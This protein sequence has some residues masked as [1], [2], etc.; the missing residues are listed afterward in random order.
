MNA[1]EYIELRQS[2]G[3]QVRRLSGNSWQVTCP[4]HEDR[5]PSLSVTAEVDRVLVKCHT[6]CP[7]EAVVAADGLDLAD[8]FYEPRKGRV[9]VEVYRYV[10]E[11]GTPLFEVVRFEPKEFRQRRP[12]GRWGIKGVRRVLY[13]LPQ[14]L[15]AV[16]AGVTIY[17]PEG[18]RDVHA[19]EREGYV[20]TC[21]PMG[22]GAGKWRDEYAETLRGANV[23]VIADRD[24][25]GRDHAKAVARSL[26]GVAASVTIVEPTVGKDVSDHLAAG[27]TVEELAEADLGARVPVDTV[28][29]PTRLRVLDV[30]RM[31]TTAPPPVPWVVEPILARGCLTMLAGR[32]GRGKSMLALALAAAVGRATLLMDVAGMPVGL[33]GHVLYVDAENGE[34]EAHRRIHGLDVEAGSLTYVEANGFD[35]KQHLGDLDRL[36]RRCEPKLLVLDSL[37]SLAPGL[38][39]NDSMQAEAALRPVVRL[40]QQ[41][42]IATLILHHANRNTGEYRG[43]TALGAAV[44]LGFTLSRIDEDPMAATR[45]KLGCWKSRPAAEPETRWLT[46]KPDPNGDILL[47]DAAPF[48]PPSRAPVREEIE[49]AIR[50]LIEGGVGCGEVYIGGHTTPPRWSTADFARAVGRD[51]KDWSVRQAVGRLA[52]AG[53]IHRNGDDRW[54]RSETLLDGEDE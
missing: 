37:R 5:T 47:S 38:D 54:Q 9:E 18:E 40:T 42:D 52:D 6:G 36:V 44:E 11:H 43:S 45:R 33:S 4:A 51:P 25:P 35:L 31:L 22:A 13:R 28:T 41:L 24:Q 10:D 53:L 15:A 16:Q 12:D 27:R 3:A 19:L 20:A 50:G 46:I 8:L 48:E 39:E 30:A 49:D 23:V 29:P 2:R 17:H 21:N 26:S 32:E 14:V 1:A 7:Q 34:N